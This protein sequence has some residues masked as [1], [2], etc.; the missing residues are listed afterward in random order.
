MT[1]RQAEILAKALKKAFG[2]K[3]EFETAGRSG[4]YRFAIVSK[5]FNS[6]PHLKR[7]DAVWEIIDRALPREV[8]LD[9]SMVLAYAPADLVPTS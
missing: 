8:T 6:M 3:V 2:G 4:R 1:L 7:Q 9:V 5:N